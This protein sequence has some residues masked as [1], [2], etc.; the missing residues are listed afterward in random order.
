MQYLGCTYTKQILLFIWNQIEL[1]L[2]V[3]S[4][5]PNPEAKFYTTLF[6]HH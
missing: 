2:C 5:S 6:D 4:G 1:G 3:L